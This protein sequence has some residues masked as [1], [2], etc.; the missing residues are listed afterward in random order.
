MKPLFPILA[1]SIAATA[2]GTVAGN[3]SPQTYPINAAGQA[4]APAPGHLAIFEQNYPRYFQFRVAELS[5]PRNS[6]GSYEKW[7][8]TFGRYLGIIGKLDGDETHR[9]LIRSYFA[10]FKREHPDKFVMVHRNFRSGDPDE[11]GPEFFAGHWLYWKGCQSL[12]D[13]VAAPGEVEIAVE[14]P[15]LFKTRIGD[16]ENNNEDLVL[17]ALNDEG[18]PDWHYAEQVKLLAVDLQKKTITIRRGAY[19]TKPKKFV[20]TRTYVAPHAYEGPFSDA[21]NL[22]W[23]YNHSVDCPR[24]LL[25]RTANDVLS[26]QLALAFAPGGKW[27]GFDGIAFDVT[28]SEIAGAAG[29][30]PDTDGDGVADHGLTAGP[31]E[32]RF[33]EGTYQFTRLL[34]QKLGAHK[35]ITGDGNLPRNGRGFD[36]FN[37]MESEGWPD[38]RDVEMKTWSDGL[39]R[40]A[41][42]RANSAQP[43]F[44]Y[45]VMKF[46]RGGKALEVPI[47]QRRL[48][49]AVAQLQ[50]TAVTLTEFPDV[51]ASGQRVA[52][53]DELVKGVE[54]VPGW[55][56][57]PLAPTVQLAKQANDL[58]GG[59]GREITAEFM[60]GV[61]AGEATQVT[62]ENGRLRAQATAS[63]AVFKLPE[64]STSGKDLA[65]FFRIRAEPA[66]G[67]SPGAG[68]LAKLRLLDAQGKLIKNGMTWCNGTDFEAFFY[69]NHVPEGRVILEIE[70][71]GG[72]PVW[73]DR[74]SAHAAPDVQYREFENG[75]VVANASGSAV[76]IQASKLWPHRQLSRLHGSV[77]Q[78]PK[79][80]DGSPIGMSIELPAKDA[81]FLRLSKPLLNKP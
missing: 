75:V 59:R 50:D 45:I 18:R 54:N 62:S 8:E 43:N 79:I 67:L 52:D 44:S 63:S 6:Y 16:N 74:I 25:G 73:I 4:T 61:R 41:F 27:A 40:L 28:W 11:D 39:N 70:M 23:M 12:T 13:L 38:V 33:T 56:G 31:G 34:R 69:C 35:L 9:H 72:A 10:R 7:A 37:G 58:F 71:E 20:A 22:L 49:M 81:L 15:T 65:I 78:D 24:D 53:W 32:N 64:I 2:F 80:N 55:L 51:A 19:W 36:Q 1:L 3:A 77:S 57:H 17:C 47:G 48:F 46:R 66:P 30:G 60:R 68:R 29:R 14:D 26:D 21:P 76:S 42:W 5:I